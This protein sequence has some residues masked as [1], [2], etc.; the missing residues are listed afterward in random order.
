MAHF[1]SQSGI[2]TAYYNSEPTD[3]YCSGTTYS[4]VL[5]C[6]DFVSIQAVL[7]LLVEEVLLIF[8]Q[9]CLAVDRIAGF[10]FIDITQ[11][12]ALTAVVSDGM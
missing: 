6:H 12:I 8:V 5:L 9:E 4:A 11:L 10:S 2:Q 3:L 7:S 1:S